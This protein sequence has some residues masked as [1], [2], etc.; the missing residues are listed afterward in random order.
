MASRRMLSNKVID[1][2]RFIKMPI[3]SQCLYFHLI[4]KA[5]DDGVVEAFN[6]MRMIGATE[7]D[8]RILVAKGFAIVLNEDLVTYIVDWKEH[9]KVRADRKVDSIYKDLLLQLVPDV[10]LLTAKPTYYQRKK[11]EASIICLTNDSIGKDRLGKYS[12]DNIYC[13]KMS[14]KEDTKVENCPPICPPKK[15]NEINF[16]LFWERYPKKV[17]KAN[18]LKWWNKNKPNEELFEKIMSGL[19]K[20]LSTSGSC[21]LRDKQYIPYPSSWLNGR[22]WEDEIEVENKDYYADVI[23]ELEQEELEKNS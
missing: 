7:D 9:N 13:S 3:S 16:E 1:S 14:D 15:E 21:L 18:A 2:A 8:L 20:Q 11:E 17:S 4:A 23:K 10:D 6:V 22:M 5:D 19:E 12:L